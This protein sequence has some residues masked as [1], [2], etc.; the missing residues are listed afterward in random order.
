MT[1]RHALALAALPAALLLA[2]SAAEAAAS[3]TLVAPYNFTVMGD[4]PTQ[5]RVRVTNQSASPVDQVEFRFANTGAATC[6][7]ENYDFPAEQAV[8]VPPGWSATTN[9]NR[10]IFAADTGADQIPNGAFVDFDL[11]LTGNGG[12]AILQ[13]GTDQSDCFDFVIVDHADGTTDNIADASGPVWTRHGFALFLDATP[14]SSIVG[15]GVSLRYLVANRTNSATAKTIASNPAAPATVPA[16][17]ATGPAATTPATLS[18]AGGASGEMSWSGTIASGPSFRFQTRVT[19]STGGTTTSPTVLSSEVSVGAFTSQLAI[20]PPKIASTTEPFTLELTVQNNGTV[21]LGNVR[22]SADPATRSATTDMV[23]TGSAAVTKLSGPTPAS[24][25]SL[26]PGQSVIFRWTY[27]VNGAPPDSIQF[28]GGAIANGTP[29]V[30]ALATSNLVELGWYSIN[31]VPRSISRGEVG[32]IVFQVA[33]NLGF[34]IDQNLQLNFPA[35]FSVA[36]ASLPGY[37]V[38]ISGG[39]RQVVFAPIA[40]NVWDSGETLNM[41][42]TFST[43]GVPAVTTD[44]YY[45]VAFRIGTSVLTR[46]P[47][48]VTA[49]RLSLAASPTTLNADG[50][51]TSTLTATLTKG[52]TAVT[53]ATVSFDTTAGTLS[54]ASAVTNASGVATV[55]LTA[56]YSS[57]TVTGTATATHINSTDAVTLTF[58]GVTGANLL[59]V[60]GSLFAKNIAPN[61]SYAFSIWVDNVGDTNVTLATGTTTINFACLDPGGAALNYAANLADPTTVNAGAGAQL[62]FASALVPNCDDTPTQ[63]VFP[64]FTYNPTRT[65]GDTLNIMTSPTFASVVDLDVE[66]AGEGAR[67]TWK[68]ELEYDNVGFRLLRAD[69]AG[70]PEYVGEFIPAS[71]AMWGDYEAVDPG[72]LGG[73]LHAWWVE[74]LDV[75]G[76]TRRHGPVFLG[77]EPCGACGGESELVALGA[78]GGRGAAVDPAVWNDPLDDGSIR[79]LSR[80]ADAIVYEIVPPSHTI[81][82]V[83]FPVALF[84]RVRIPG[85]SVLQEPGEPDLPVRH[86]GVPVP[87]GAFASLEILEI[88][89]VEISGVQPTFDAGAI[90]APDASIAPAPSPIFARRRS[91]STTYPAEP[92]SLAELGRLGSSPVVFLA[93]TPLRFDAGTGTLRSASRVVVRV[94]FHAAAPVERRALSRHEAAQAAIVTGA[95]VRVAATR[96]GLVRVPLA[97]IEAAGVAPASAAVWRRGEVVPSRIEGAELVFATGV[98]PESAWSRDSVFWIAPGSAA[99]MPRVEPPA[100]QLAADVTLRTAHLEDDTWFAPLSVQ[101]DAEDRWFWKRIFTGGPLAMSVTIPVAAVEATASAGISLELKGLWDEANAEP[102]HLVRVWMNGADLG[103]TTLAAYERVHRSFAI[104]AGVLVAGDNT[105]SIES[106]SPFVTSVGLDSVELT[107]TAA[108]DALGAA[109]LPVIAPASGTLTATGLSAPVSFAIDETVPALLAASSEPDGVG[110]WRASVTAVAGHSVRFLADDAAPAATWA[111]HAPVDVLASTGADYVV[112]AASSLLDAARGFADYR[113]TEAGG[114]MRTAV[115]DASDLYDRFTF[116]DVDPS[117]ARLFLAQARES[118]PA[119]AAR[120]VLLVG[121]SDAD[122]LDHLGMGVPGG[123][124][125]SERVDTEVLNAAS[126]SKSAAFVGADPIPDVALGRIPARD[127]SD[128]AAALAKTIAYESAP[129]DGWDTRQTLLSDDDLP[130]FGAVRAE[131]AAMRPLLMT[132]DDLSA[133]GLGDTAAS[134]SLFDAL[135]EGRALATYVGHGG[136]TTLGAEPYLSSSDA[137]SIAVD[138]GRYPV[139]LAVDCMNG[140]FDHPY[141]DALSEELVR[142]PDAGAA[143]FFGSTAVTR[144]GGHRDLALA[145]HHAFWREPDLRL[146]DVALRAYTSVAWRADAADLIGSFVLFG[147]PAL[148]PNVDGTPTAVAQ[149]DSVGA[150]SAVLTAAASR[151]PENAPLA[152]RWEILEGPAGA[153]LDDDASQTPVLRGDPGRYRVR[154][155]VADAHRASA[156]DEIV[157]ELRNP[158][159]G[160]NGGEPGFFGCS[161]SASAAPRGLFGVLLTLGL[162]IA[163]SLRRRVLARRVV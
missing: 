29:N 30:T 20:V 154:L 49:Q 140:Y 112:I 108:A 50:N 149:I 56:P 14:A 48:L 85:W 4:G 60:G 134:A 97:E 148:K 45:L 61:T 137:P 81:E 161:V 67:L 43:T 79:V 78:A 94:S 127:A 83:P 33:Q 106:E 104:P 160:G 141:F 17:S 80:D 157:V 118:W 55:T 58:N 74:D 107:W 125:L 122:P 86:L 54:A 52:G 158:A 63:S 87:A 153:T 123:M 2:P 120:Y 89:E 111:A 32:P 96:P 121:D 144:D 76:N 42:I 142:T 98:P 66:A 10:A 135:V 53:G 114:S 88:D 95:A 159:G 69:G 110:G 5:L 99:A 37:T 156:P 1:L 21:A 25:S 109:E 105:L 23:F 6:G 35:G 28:Q 101:G 47:L 77:F 65:I 68:T 38:T 147:D 3:A 51:A 163:L 146:G 133:E 91:V 31:V 113:R 13:S 19:S 9:A 46:L 22:P 27:D 62:T 143:A 12:A 11:R 7:T 139:V 82:A 57:T 90:T 15:G 131:L 128:V 24:V 59:Y 71:G 92:A 102:E 70:E 44:T 130:E 124:L 39:N 126:D 119:P 145:F 36:A 151:D 138:G 40:P 73:G 100:V 115:V 26:A 162:G 16:G 41:A 116:G 155:R 152:H 84:D 150:G 103:T 75:D 18:L 64:T 93:A 132:A 129:R 34:A 136:V 117:A 72:P 8:T